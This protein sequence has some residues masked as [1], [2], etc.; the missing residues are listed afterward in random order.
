MAPTFTLLYAGLASLL[1][2]ALSY[3]VVALRRRHQVGIGTGSVNALERAIRAQANFS[4]YV[5]LA[6][7]LLALLEMTSAPALLIHALGV[8]LILGRVLHAIG[9]NRSA[10]ISSGRFVG[11]LLTW[12]VLLIGGLFATARALLQLLG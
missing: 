12:L 6:L 7:L 9:L 11:T 5:P 2:I 8:A 4:E 3:R 10:G 1:L